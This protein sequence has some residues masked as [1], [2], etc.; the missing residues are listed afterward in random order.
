MQSHVLTLTDTYTHKSRHAFTVTCTH[1]SAYTYTKYTL[2]TKRFLYTHN[3][4]CYKELYTH[5]DMWSLFR[6]II[7]PTKAYCTLTMQLWLLNTC[8]PT[9]RYLPFA[10]HTEEEYAGA[11][12]LKKPHGTDSLAI[13]DTVHSKEMQ[14]CL[15]VLYCNH[16]KQN[17]Q[18]YLLVIMSL[19]ISYNCTVHCYG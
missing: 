15:N 8:Q 16:D 18:K 10:S 19:S 6:N 7:S 11:Y 4:H 12:Q 5:A 13:P 1:T 14:F 17:E 9:K 2:S 3:T